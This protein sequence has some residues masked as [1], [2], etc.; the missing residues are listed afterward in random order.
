[1]QK[2]TFYQRFEADILSGKK[3]ITIRNKSDKDYVPGTV[4]RLF[5][6]EEDRGFG[7]ITILSVESI[8][9]SQLTLEHA[10]QENMS[11]VELKKTIQRIY[12]NTQNLYVIS[13]RLL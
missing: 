8:L 7:S 12:P 9:F 13:F 3:T 10:Q 11:L 1:M 5:T 4:V 6:Y 2:L